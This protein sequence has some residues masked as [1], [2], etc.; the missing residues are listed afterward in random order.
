MINFQSNVVYGPKPGEIVTP[1][2]NPVGGVQQINPVLPNVSG[3]NISS[4]PS[5]YPPMGGPNITSGAGYPNTSGFGGYQHTPHP[6]VYPYPE[7]SDG[8]HASQVQ[9]LPVGSS[10]SGN[11]E[12]SA[13]YYEQNNQGSMCPPSYIEATTSQSNM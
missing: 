1:Y 11:V 12:A 4:Y 5:T 6:A 13:P 7:K 3:N 9:N 8:T 2:G 10:L